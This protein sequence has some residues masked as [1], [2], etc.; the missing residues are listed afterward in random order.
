MLF[1][2]LQI[3][4]VERKELQPTYKSTLTINIFQAPSFDG[5]LHLLN[6]PKSVADKLK[7][8]SIR[9]VPDLLLL[10]EKDIEDLGL[11]IGGRS[12]LRAAVTVMR[13]KMQ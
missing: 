4:I 13:E 11:N 2:Y 3:Y 5:F 6:V 1:H 8:H 12:R 10:T 7:E 9:N